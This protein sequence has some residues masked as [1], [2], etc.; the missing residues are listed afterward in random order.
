M[1]SPREFTL[2]FRNCVLVALALLMCTLHAG[3]YE[4]L[5]DEVLC[6]ITGGDGGDEVQYGPWQK[7]GCA[8]TTYYCYLQPCAS[9]PCTTCKN[10]AYRNWQCVEDRA[11]AQ[12]RCRSVTYVIGCGNMVLNAECTLGSCVKTANSTSTVYEC[13]R[14]YY[15]G[16]IC[17]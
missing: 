14:Y 17:D 3:A 1:E 15:E 16:D 9:S 11:D 10:A 12:D 6:S 7:P 4:A 13:T 2:Y 5:P 8:E